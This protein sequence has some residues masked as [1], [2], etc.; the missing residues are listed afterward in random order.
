M[1]LSKTEICILCICICIIS[2]FAY[3]QITYPRL[4]NYILTNSII[5]YSKE[6]VLET[7]QNGDLIFLSGTTYAE[8]MCKWLGDCIFSHIGLLFRENSIIYIVDCDIGQSF[9]DGFRVSPL[10]T[11]LSKYK[12]DKISCIKQ[13]NGIR[14]NPSEISKIINE[15]MDIDFSNNVLRWTFSEY[16]KYPAK[17]M[18]CSEFISYFLQKLHILKSKEEGGKN[19]CWYTPGEYFKNKIQ[20]H[21]KDDY[22]FGQNIFFRF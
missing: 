8:N 4:Q 20:H 11:K 21:F 10:E 14:P 9:K 18:F 7:V 15:S 5:I 22:F 19:P 3:G 13:L 2:F 17:E 1:R 12:G 6:D 16:T